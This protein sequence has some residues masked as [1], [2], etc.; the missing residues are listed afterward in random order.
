MSAADKTPDLESIAN[1][2]AG[3]EWDFHPKDEGVGLLSP[4]SR[5]FNG[6]PWDGQ[7]EGEEPRPAVYPLGHGGSSGADFSDL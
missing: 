2:L 3:T 4:M 1:L 5:Y 6:F 7:E